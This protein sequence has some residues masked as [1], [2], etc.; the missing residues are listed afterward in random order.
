MCK[1]R[2]RYELKKYTQNYI[3]IS[4]QSIWIPFLE[5]DDIVRWSKQDW[6]IENKE[7]V[8]NS[9]SL[10]TNGKDMMSVSM[11]NLDEISR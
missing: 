9:I 10:P 4:I 5:P 11:T 2:A 6:G 3:S 1:E 7:F 8:I